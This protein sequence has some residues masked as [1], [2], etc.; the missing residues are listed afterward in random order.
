[1][2]SEPDV[3]LCEC[4][5]RDGLQ[6]EAQVIPA[7]AKAAMLNRIA[8]CGFRRVEITSF[9][10]PKYVPQ[11]ADA[12]AVLAEI[13]VTPEQLAALRERGVV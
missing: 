4:F 13:G 9:A 5:A 12:D 6:H 8:D 1:M 10:H 7:D 3:V 2:P 11:F